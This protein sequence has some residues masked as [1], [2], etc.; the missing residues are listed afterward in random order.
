MVADKFKHSLLKFFYFIYEFIFWHHTALPPQ[1]FSFTEN[2]KR[3]N[4]TYLVGS[5]CLG[6]LSTSILI[7]LAASFTSSFTCFRIGESALQG[8]TILQKNLPARFIGI[9]HFVKV[10][11]CHF[12]IWKKK[13]LNA[14]IMAPYKLLLTG[15]DVMAQVPVKQPTYLPIKKTLPKRRT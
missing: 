11:R 15:L 12:L 4:S 5:R 14:P 6:F 9:D 1:N 10:I 3:W 8:R 7:I 13:T 2:Y